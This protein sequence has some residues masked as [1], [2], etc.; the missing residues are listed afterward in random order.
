MHAARE[1]AMAMP[2]EA[3]ELEVEASVTVTWRLR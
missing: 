3:G 1:M 2:V